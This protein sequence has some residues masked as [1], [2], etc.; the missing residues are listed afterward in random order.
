V[1]ALERNVVLGTIGVNGILAW[2]RRQHSPSEI[3]ELL[4]S[5]RD[6][7]TACVERGQ[8]FRVDQGRKQERHHGDR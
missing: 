6:I 1:D 5:A 3:S 8:F 7:C 4:W 2:D